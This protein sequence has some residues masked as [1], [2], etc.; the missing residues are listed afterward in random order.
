MTENAKEAKITLI[1]QGE[2]DEQTICLAC[3]FCCDGTLFSYASLLKE[4]D[5][6]PLVAS[7]GLTLTESEEGFCL[8]CHHHSKQQGCQIYQ[9]PKPDVCGSYRCRLLNQYRLGK[10]SLDKAMALVKEGKTF[11]Q[12]IIEEASVQNIPFEHGVAMVEL[13]NYLAQKDDPIKNQEYR[14]L[15]LLWHSLSHLLQ[16]WF[17]RKGQK[18]TIS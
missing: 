18:N 6:R 13:S 15:L 9:Q 14:Y 10:V 3:G 2:N 16:K 5:E 8:P 17:I 7:L 12:K 4:E 1:N 11:R